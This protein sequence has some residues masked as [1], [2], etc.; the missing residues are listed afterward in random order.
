MIARVTGTGG[1]TVVITDADYPSERRSA[2]LK[3]RRALLPA[4]STCTRVTHLRKRKE[5]KKETREKE[6]VVLRDGFR[7]ESMCTYVRTYV[8]KCDAPR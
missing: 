5:R 4:S 1:V 6:R 2:L 8:R 3:P 7:R